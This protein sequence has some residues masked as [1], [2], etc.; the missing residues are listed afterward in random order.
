V[1]DWR[2]GTQIAIGGNVEALAEI[3]LRRVK[4]GMVEDWNNGRLDLSET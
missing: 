4:N 2:I 1:E 3:P